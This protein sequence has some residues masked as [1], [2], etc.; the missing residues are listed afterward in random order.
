M[1]PTIKV[2]AKAVHSGRYRYG[3]PI[4]ERAN[5]QNAK[6][7]RSIVGGGMEAKTRLIHNVPLQLRV[8]VVE[9]EKKIDEISIVATVRI[10]NIFGKVLSLFDYYYL[11]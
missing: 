8:L 3:A 7:N 1:T 5:K 9:L 10:G 6:L 2:S 4:L 11:L